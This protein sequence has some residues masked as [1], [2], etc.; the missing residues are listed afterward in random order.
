MYALIKQNTVYGHADI[1]AQ[2]AD[3][4]NT[5]GEY[6]AVEC[7]VVPENGSFY[8]AAT[9][10]FT[11]PI[12]VATRKSEIMARLAAIDNITTKPRTTRE[13]L[14]GN[15]DTIAWVAGLDAEAH[16]LRTELATL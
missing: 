11:T 4:I 16:D 8:D 15:A 9:G 5:A 10:T 6:L 13:L 1:N 7:S 14:L 12:L 2:V 3:E